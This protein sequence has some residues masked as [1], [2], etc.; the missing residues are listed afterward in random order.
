MTCNFSAEDSIR[1]FLNEFE[2][3]TFEKMLEWSKSL[4]YHHRRLSSE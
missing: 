2:D 3:E 1:Y 4:N